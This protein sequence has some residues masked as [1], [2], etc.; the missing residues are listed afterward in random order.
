MKTKISPINPKVFHLTPEIPCATN[1]YPIVAPTT[2]C[3]PDTGRLTK[4]ATI[5]HS[6]VPL[7]ALREPIIASSSVPLKEVISMMP[8]LT[9]SINKETT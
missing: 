6:P 9:V 3:V 7:R 1:A 5:S 2:L 4:V 8:F